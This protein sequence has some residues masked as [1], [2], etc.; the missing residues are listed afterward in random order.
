[1]EKVLIIGA[2][3]FLGRRL[4]SRFQATHQVYG[5]DINIANILP[6]FNP[7][8]VDITDSNAVSD[9]LSEIHPELTILTAAIAN[10]DLCED[11]PEV[12]R[13]VNADGP[14]F[15]AQAVKKIN[16]RMIYISTD[17]IFDGTT[18]DYSE[19]D[20]PNPNGVYA[21]TKFEGERNVVQT[22]IPA[23]I[24][25]SSI[26]FGW[27]DA[28]QHAN[29]FSWAYKQLN[30]GNP[31]KIVDGQITTSTLVDDLVEFL[32]RI[33][34]FQTSE[35]YHSCGPEPISKYEFITKLVEVFHFDPTLV[36]KISHFPQKAP[37]PENSSLNTHKIQA[38][39]IH[40][41]RTISE[42]F[43]F[44]QTQMNLKK[45]K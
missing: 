29:I 21:R 28:D 33:S 1:M 2:N 19:T 38:L 18:G 30:Q 45:N 26:L 22:A 42:S 39:G 7:C 44:L 36:Q 13:K 12:V 20:Q 35:I 5:A 32:F 41:F 37:R 6:R 14:L 40:P 10:V 25:R 17:F 43:R 3:G 31:I 9:L 11:I 23:L 27:P 4:L 16:G 34:D 24:C 15:V 8:L